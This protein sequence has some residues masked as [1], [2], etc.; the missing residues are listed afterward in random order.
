MV[1]AD[2][3]RPILLARRINT[4]I[5]MA[6]FAP[7]TA[8]KWVRERLLKRLVMSVESPLTSPSVIPKAKAFDCAVTP[9][10]ACETACRAV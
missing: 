7:E 8:V 9:V 10:A 2:L 1:L 4:P 3:P 5:R 6:Q